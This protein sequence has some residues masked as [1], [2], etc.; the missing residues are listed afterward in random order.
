[1]TGNQRETALGLPSSANKSPRPVWGAAV[2]GILF[3]Q[4]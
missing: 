4:Q 1:M 3:A 2:I